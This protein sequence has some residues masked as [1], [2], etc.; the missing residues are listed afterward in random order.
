M[1]LPVIILVMFLVIFESMCQWVYDYSHTTFFCLLGLF[2]LG[3]IFNLMFVSV[4]SVARFYNHFGLFLFFGGL[5]SRI[6]GHARDLGF[7]YIFCRP[8]LFIYV[9]WERLNQKF[10]LNFLSFVL[11]CLAML[12]NNLALMGIM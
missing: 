8:S 9:S 2:I 3:F 10:W 7:V 5:W 1:F 12:E 4:L 6:G 11:L